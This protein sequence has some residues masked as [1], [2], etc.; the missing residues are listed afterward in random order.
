MSEH[1]YH[2][3][4]IHLVDSDPL[5]TDL[6]Q[7]Q[8]MPTC[9]FHAGNCWVLYTTCAPQRIHISDGLWT[10]IFPNP[11]FLLVIAFQYSQAITSLSH[12]TNNNWRILYLIVP[13]SGNHLGSIL[14][15]SQTSS[16]WGVSF[17][18][19]DE[20]LVGWKDSWAGNHYASL[21]GF[22]ITVMGFQTHHALA[23]FEHEKGSTK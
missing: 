23:M 18:A 22:I 13:I 6:L 19:D 15:G 16:L 7:S 12:S 3:T 1:P 2:N 20:S 17:L 10:S 9:D 5:C 4:T 11:F 14:A 21:F 8:N